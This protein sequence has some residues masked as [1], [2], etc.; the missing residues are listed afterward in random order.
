MQDNTN[1]ISEYRNWIGGEWKTSSDSITVLNPWNGQ[2]VSKACL[3]NPSQIDTA[4]GHAVGAKAPFRKT[5]RFLR[6]KLLGRMTALLEEQSEDLAKLILAEAGKPI[7]LARVEVTR[8]INTFRTA[9][10]ETNRMI[11]ESYPMDID[12]VGRGYDSGRTEFF[13]RGIVLAITPFNFPLNLVAHKLAPALAVGAPIILKPAPQAPGSAFR[14]AEIFE[15]ARQ[16]ANR[17]FG[18]DTDSIPPAAYQ[19]VMCSNENASNLTKDHRVSTISFTGS[20]AVGWKIQSQ[21]VKKKVLLELGGNAAVVVTDCADLRVA[22][23]KSAIAATA[24]SGQSCISVQRIFVDAM[25][26][27]QFREN[28]VEEFQKIP[29]GDPEDPKVLVGPMID[30]SAVHRVKDWIREAIDS[31]AKLLIGGNSDNSVLHPTLLENVPEHCKIS[32][33]EV[34]GPV[35]ILEKTASFQDSIEKVNSSRYG[36]HAGVFTNRIGE[37]QEAFRELEVGGV[38]INEVPAFRADQM[39]YGGVKESGLGREGI[40]Y[41]MED[42]CERKTLIIR[43]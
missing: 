23:S 33:E 7:A 19:V 5:S 3:A 40:R 43:F 41:A 22:A 39:P 2:I 12:A 35:A 34:F 15:E 24:Y 11:G 10:E 4:L 1:G 18:T 8:C 25:I 32:C 36:L 16:M 14:L 21:S 38:L 27:E 28:L 37:I 6:S 30:E 9:T 13:P 31:G 20:T 42:Y 17:N 26:Y 29:V